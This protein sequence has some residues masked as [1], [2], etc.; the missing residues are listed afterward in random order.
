MPSL[1]TTYFGE[2]EYGSDSVF[3]FPSGIPGFEHH[4]QFLLVEQAQSHPVVFVQSL[5]SP[6]LCFIA[7]PVLVVDPRYRLELSEEDLASLEFPNSGQPRIGEDVACLALVTVTEN[8]EPT[9]NL[10]SPLVLNLK[11]RLGI[12]I[13]HQDV[14]YSFRQPIQ[15]HE[16]STRCSC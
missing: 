1:P 13:I 2:L 9:A 15:T 6:D 11:Q 12:Q 10:R 5:L 4:S 14:G 8:S 3:E 16:E 7:L